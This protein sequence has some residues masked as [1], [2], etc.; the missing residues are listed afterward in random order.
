MV[1]AISSNALPRL[2]SYLSPRSAADALAGM[3]E[4]LYGYRLSR[5]QQYGF[6]F[7]LRRELPTWTPETPRPA[8]VLTSD[9]GIADFRRLG[10]QFPEPGARPGQ[11]RLVHLKP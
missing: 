2:D 7:Y 9:E 1:V 4:P 6:D 5:S 8:W 10:L 3:Q 11:I